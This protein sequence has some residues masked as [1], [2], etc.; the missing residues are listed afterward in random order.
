VAN[1]SLAYRAREE[2][3]IGGAW[4]SV[5]PSSHRPR[6]TIRALSDVTLSVSR[7]QT[8]GIVGTNGAGKSSLLKVIAGVLPPTSGR[9]TV[10][11]EIGTLLSL[12]VGFRGHL[13]GREN[14]VLSGLA[15]GLTRE[16]VDERM[17]EIVAFAEL[18]DFI[19]LP[20]RTYSSGMSARLAFAS[21]TTVSPD[22]LLVDEALSAGDARF[23]KKAR[24]RMQSL[25]TTSG[26]VVLV[27]HSLDA[28]ETMCD[29]IAWIDGGRIV[30]E[31]DPVEIVAQYLEREHVSRTEE[32]DGNL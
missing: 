25:I 20:V 32:R 23:K 16:Q 10:H 22:I 14:V 19:D 13:S 1:V 31:G 6:R 7:G 17:D 12:G 29:R 5:R 3:T 28:L 18:E 2:Q 27:S 11:G 30:A 8:F 21:A 4:R 26:T 15:A 24:E 9:V